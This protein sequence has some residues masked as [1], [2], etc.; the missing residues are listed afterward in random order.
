[1]RS[2][3]GGVGMPTGDGVTNSPSSP[4]ISAMTP[5]N[6]AC[7]CVRSRCAFVTSTRASA[8]RVASSAAAQP[9]AVDSARPSR[10]VGGFLGREP[11]GAQLRQA[12]GVALGD[13]GDDAGFARARA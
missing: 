1:M 2:T 11:V 10:L 7:S 6:G 3:V 8:T 12:L 4:L 13:R 9:A 5:A